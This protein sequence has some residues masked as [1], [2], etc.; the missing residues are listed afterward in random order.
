MAFDSGGRVRC[1][2]IVSAMG[3]PP[4]GVRL[5]VLLFFGLIFSVS[6]FL[7]PSLARFHSGA[8]AYPKGNPRWPPIIRSPFREGRPTKPS[9]SKSQINTMKTDKNSQTATTSGTLPQPEQT[10]SDS[11]SNQ[12][13]KGR[14][15]YEAWRA[16][17]RPLKNYFNPKAEYD[18]TLYRSIGPD[19][20]FVR[21]CPLRNIWTLTDMCGYHPM[22]SEGVCNFDRRG[23]FITEVPAPENQRFRIELASDNNDQ[24]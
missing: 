1:A 8:D 12:P 20:S 17:Y 24:E 13:S 19:F 22:I 11:N 15:S 14:M 10:V 9:D 21:R 5:F 6:G 3:R 4:G 2:E 18:G 16:K 23:Y 7:S